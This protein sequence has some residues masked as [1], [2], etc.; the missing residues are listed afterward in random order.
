MTD[1]LPRSLVED[2]YVQDARGDEVLA[3]L[4]THLV[5]AEGRTPKNQ[6]RPWCFLA[7]MRTLTAGEFVV[8][9]SQPIWA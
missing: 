4:Q 1:E 3:R 9:I 5:L 8:T 6:K 2:F 7:S